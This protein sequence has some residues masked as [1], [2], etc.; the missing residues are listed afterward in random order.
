METALPCITS[1]NPFSWSQHLLWVEHAH[2]TIAVTSTSLS[3]FQCVYDQSPLN[4]MLTWGAT[5]HCTLALHS[6]VGQKVWLVPRFVGPFPISKVINPAA[7]RVSLHCSMR[8]HPMFYV[9]RVKPVKTSKLVTKKHTHFWVEGGI[10]CAAVL[11]MFCLLFF[12][13][14]HGTAMCRKCQSNFQQNW[15][16][17][18][19]PDCGN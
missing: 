19:L 9:S 4:L 3:P 17:S 11:N 15:D 5:H 6:W 12:D 1:Q 7:V 13:V 16:K 14:L 2:N 18:L 10:Q 8:V